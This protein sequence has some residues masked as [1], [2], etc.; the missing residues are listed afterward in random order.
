MVDAWE[1]LSNNVDFAGKVMPTKYHI[2]IHVRGTSNN[3]RVRLN[4]DRKLVNTQA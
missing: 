2:E 3:K 4:R 1:I